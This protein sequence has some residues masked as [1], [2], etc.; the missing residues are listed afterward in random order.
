MCLHVKKCSSIC[1]LGLFTDFLKIPCYLFFQCVFC[2]FFFYSHDAW[3]LACHYLSLF[4]VVFICFSVCFI[5]L[6][7]IWFVW[8]ACFYFV[9]NFIV[10]Y[11]LFFFLC[12]K[13][14]YFLTMLFFAGL[15]FPMLFSLLSWFHFCSEFALVCSG[16]FLFSCVLCVI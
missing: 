14:C 2:S 6:I 9:L 16:C 4:H 15:F 11:W 8:T 13:R 7:I 12:F 1:V 5:F 3:F 10:C